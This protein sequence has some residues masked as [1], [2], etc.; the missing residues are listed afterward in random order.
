[1]EFELWV[2]SD[3]YR[4]RRPWCSFEGRAMRRASENEVRALLE[5]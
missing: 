3:S 5:A 1:V 2:F 4:H